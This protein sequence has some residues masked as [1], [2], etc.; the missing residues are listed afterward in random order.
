MPSVKLSED[1][2]RAVYTILR[3]SYFMEAWLSPVVGF[4]AANARATICG[5]GRNP[6]SWISVQDVAEFALASLDN[7]A[8]KNAVIELGGPEALSPLQVIHRF[9]EITGRPFEVQFVPEEALKGQQDAATDPMQ[10][11]FSCLMR[12]YAS[13]DPID[14]SA[15][16]GTFAIEPT[17]VEQYARHVLTPA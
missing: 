12:C 16:L 1:G 9:E 2:K 5:T 10:Q 11:S 17:T 7:P 15:T 3:P 13:G 14:M 8:A 6:I 4:D